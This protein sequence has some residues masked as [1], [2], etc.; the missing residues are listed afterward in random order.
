[1]VNQIPN[2][3][4]G[5]L[6]LPCHYN[7]DMSDSMSCVNQTYVFLYSP[8][9]C[10]LTPTYFTNISLALLCVTPDFYLLLFS[11]K[12]GFLL[13]K[14]KGNQNLQE[15][16]SLFVVN[17]VDR[18]VQNKTVLLP[19]SSVFHLF[20]SGRFTLPQPCYQKL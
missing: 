17:P 12:Y 8:N 14:K 20:V 19:F 1:M 6:D 16:Y 13:K 9:L 5:D 7:H 2:N 18:T 15:A 11:Y 4:K 10:F 3:T